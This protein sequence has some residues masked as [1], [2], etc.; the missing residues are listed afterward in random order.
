[1]SCSPENK[2]RIAQKITIFSNSNKNKSIFFSKNSIT[3]IKRIQMAKKYIKI[4]IKE[5]HG[6]EKATT[7]NI[8]FSIFKTK[9]FF[10]LS[11]SE[12]TTTTTTRYEQERKVFDRIF[13]R[14]INKCHP[15]FIK[16]ITIY[17]KVSSR[18]GREKTG[19]IRKNKK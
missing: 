2:Q 12:T 17:N 11:F 9:Y 14:S 3:K 6:H 8:I 13:Q 5:R 7:T 16:K 19:N 1:M 10:M 15:M 4:K 18:F